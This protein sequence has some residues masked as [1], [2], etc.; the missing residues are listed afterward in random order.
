[1]YDDDKYNGYSN[2]SYTPNYTIVGGDEPKKN[3]RSGTSK[4]LGMALFFALCMAGS[5]GLSYYVALQTVEQE[6]AKLTSGEKADSRSTFTPTEAQ[7]TSNQSN[8]TGGENVNAIAAVSQKAADSVVEIS[9]E[10]KQGNTFLPQYV[11]EGAGSG[12]IISEDGYIAT[13]HHV[14]DGA[15]SIKV[16]TTDGT[17]YDAKLVATDEKTDLAVLKIEANGLKA[18]SFADSSKAVVGQLAVAIGNPL[19]ELGGTVTDGIVSALDREVTIDNKTMRLMQTSAA[20]NPGNSGGGL[21]DGDGNLIGIINAKTSGSDVEGLA[22]AIP[23]NTVKEV[24]GELIDNGYV[25]GRPVIGINVTEIDEMSAMMQ[26]RGQYAP[27]VYV[28][29]S[30]ADNGLEAGDRIISINGEEIT[31]ASQ[32]SAS[33]EDLS[34]GDKITMEI[35][36]DGDKQTVEVTLSE[37]TPEPTAVP[38]SA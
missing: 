20:V 31:S 34:V 35:E 10:M 28:A 26:Y 5:S 7:Y 18:A 27:G 23:A 2:S 25:T 30:T 4:K 1:M 38:K 11:S 29:E 21:F 13:N 16:T 33:L 3:K 36:R 15:G 24:V 19:G 8:N 12:V 14:I 17:E 37:Y 32:V 22:F 6:A 9:T